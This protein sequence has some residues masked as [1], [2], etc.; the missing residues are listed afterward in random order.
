MTTMASGAT[1]SSNFSATNS[2]SLPGNRSKIEPVAGTAKI[3]HPDED[4]SLVSLNLNRKTKSN[5]IIIC[6]SLGRISCFFAE[7]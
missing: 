4:I 1:A 2:G 3:I 7:I 6:Y 5:Q